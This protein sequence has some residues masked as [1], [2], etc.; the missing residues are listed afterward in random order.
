MGSVIFWLAPMD[1]SISPSVYPSRTMT[2]NSYTT[3]QA[4]QVLNLSTNAVAVYCKR[5]GVG[6]K[7]GRDWLLTDN[8]M[9]IIKLRMGKRGPKPK[10]RP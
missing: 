5:Y 7:H 6:T 3:A 8:D 9:Q 10:P 1:T 2:Q 4:A